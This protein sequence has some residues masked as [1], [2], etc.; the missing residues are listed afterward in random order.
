MHRETG[1]LTWIDGAV[2]GKGRNAQLERLAEVM[3]WSRIL[4]V[5][6]A[7]YAA[8]T[9]RPAYP[10]LV[11]VKAL[12]LAQWHRLSD[13]LLEQALSDRI[14]FRRFVGLSLED[15]TPD[16][17]TICRFR[18]QLA[19]QGLDRALFEEVNAQLDAR[20]L[21]IKRGTLMDATVLEAQAARPGGEK[22]AR[23]AVDPDADWTRVRGQSHF[24]YKA[25]LGV[26]QK[27]GIVRRAELTSARISESEQAD[28]LICGDE[29][30]VYGDRAYQQ[31]KRSERLQAWGIKDRIMRRR[32]KTQA[33]LPAGQ[34]R[35]NRR[36]AKVRWQVEGVFGIL[37]RIYGY[38]RVRYYSLQANTAQLLLLLTAYNLRKA[39]ALA[40]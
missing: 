11:M 10:P 22:A 40:A 39:L 4:A 30:A 6:K 12:L 3:D 15:D 17:S 36:I 27:S 21:V 33:V 32:H 16:H 26:D 5:L 28:A 38:T 24:G 1:Q 31:R 18:Q 35:R 14:S 20:G 13:P 37:K 34:L 7:V 2:A 19:E 25:H 23:S 9:G 8:E 29:H